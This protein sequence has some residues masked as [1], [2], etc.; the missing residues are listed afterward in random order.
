MQT[1]SLVG[2]IT[3]RRTER[4]LVVVLVA[5]RAG[6]GVDASLISR[7][8]SAGTLFARIDSGLSGAGGAGEAL[9]AAAPAGRGQGGTSPGVLKP[10]GLIG[11]CFSPLDRRAR[12]GS[13]RRPARTWISSISQSEMF[14]QPL[15][16]RNIGI[17]QRGGGRLQEGGGGG[18][19]PGINSFV[20]P[21]HP[22]CVLHTIA[23][24][25][26]VVV[27]SNYTNNTNNTNSREGLLP[28]RLLSA[29]CSTINSN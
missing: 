14:F 20:V 29:L 11:P 23:S 28:F 18:R 7:P 6:V 15:L 8:A 13:R 17:A 12:A 24:G 26:G 25:W 19:R 10:S 27:V 5:P 2:N 3:D 22:T 1:H 21:G 4:T 16:G 9:A